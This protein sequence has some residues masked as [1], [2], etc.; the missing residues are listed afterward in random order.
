MK[1]GLEFEWLARQQGLGLSRSG[2]R[3][4]ILDG[5]VFYSPNSPRDVSLPPSPTQPS[6]LRRTQR[7]YPDARIAPEKDE[8][9]YRVLDRPAPILRNPAIDD[10]SEFQQPQ[11]WTREYCHLS[12][13]PLES[14]TTGL[15]NKIFSTQSYPPR[16][17]RGYSLDPKTILDWNHLE[18]DLR[19]VIKA[20]FERAHIRDIPQIFHTA[21]VC[22][23]TYGDVASFH[24]AVSRSK[25]WFRYWIGMLSYA[26]A[27][28]ITLDEIN[29]YGHL[30][31]HSNFLD[32]TPTSTYIVPGWY[33][34][35][36]GSSW[37][38]MY[39]WSVHSAAG[40]FDP[41]IARAG[42]FLNVLNPVPDQFSIDWFCQFNIP[43]WYPWGAAESA[44]ALSD[45]N[46][47]RF[48]P[49]PHQLQLLASSSVPRSVTLNPCELLPYKTLED[50]RH[51]PSWQ[52]FFSEREQRNK[53]L[54]KQMSPDALRSYNSRMLQPPSKSCRVYVWVK[55]ESSYCRIGVA[56]VSFEDVWED[57][58]RHQRSY[59]ALENS[60]D[61]CKEFAEDDL[62]ELDHYDGDHSSHS[63]DDSGSQAVPASPLSFFDDL[64][65]SSLPSPSHGLSRLS[66]QPPDP[67]VTSDES[68]GSPSSPYPVASSADPIGQSSDKPLHGLSSL[69]CSL[70][71]GRC[72]IL[73]P[74]GER[75]EAVHVLHE[76]FGFVPPLPLIPKPRA[77]LP[78]PADRVRFHAVLGMGGQ[79]DHAFF[80]SPYGNYAVDFLKCLD[81]SPVRL[82]SGDL[83][84]S[85]DLWDLALNNRM[86]M[87]LRSHLRVLRKISDS[88][89]V[90]E[91]GRDATVSWTL[92]VFD[93][94]AAL[95]ACRLPEQLNDY[96][97]AFSLLQRGIPF[98]TLERSSSRV[99]R[100]PPVQILPI[101]LQADFS[102]DDYNVYIREREALLSNPRIA[103]AGLLKGGI[104]WRLIG[105]ACQFATVLLGPTVAATSGKVGLL[106]ADGPS[107][108]LCDD[109]ISER[110]MD[111]LCGTIVCMTGKT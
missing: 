64:C 70:P 19:H 76:Y 72:P 29:Q 48:S 57:Y 49:L 28:S 51:Y 2:G 26:I 13:I 33:S 95:L 77:S 41:S 53:K 102:N 7:F 94:A 103:R 75:Y 5:H 8:T 30:D 14:I 91:F 56:K 82:Q 61:C 87:G 97:L 35:L 65:G 60:W 101:R 39:L 81:I 80:D 31:Y 106:Y 9:A 99:L 4:Q 74:V 22:A 73:D 98:T 38:E 10:V 63:D 79:P 67:F 3:C 42:I 21:L 34:Y 36:A 1:T 40:N 88:L 16:G 11:W 110:E 45:P 84:P 85:S 86:Y 83:V 78:T 18:Y 66:P 108:T 71:R 20:L 50:I 46:L 27:A 55:S 24:Q 59:D 12:F 44:A 100:Q 6:I 111:I 89:F 62:D 104:I 54:L 109:I 92:G 68:F 17:R 23:G 107:Q 69:I 15:L 47:S 52:S 93:A 32:N 96:D 58:A 105:Q 43:V 90:F 37:H 25:E